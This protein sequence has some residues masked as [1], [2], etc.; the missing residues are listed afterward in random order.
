MRVENDHRRDQPAGYVAEAGNNAEKRIETDAPPPAQW[1][2]PVEQ[3]RE[4][5]DPFF[6][7]Y[8]AR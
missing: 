3:P 5:L 8:R 1:D 7:G 4:L 2:E 6:T